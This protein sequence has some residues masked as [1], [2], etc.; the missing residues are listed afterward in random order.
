ML[1]SGVEQY[2]TRTDG[3]YPYTLGMRNSIFL[4]IGYII[5]FFMP[6]KELRNEDS[7]E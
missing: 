3:S 5:Y 1:F 2:K 7:Q 4:Y 6:Y